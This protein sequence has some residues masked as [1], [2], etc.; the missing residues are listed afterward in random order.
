MIFKVVVSLL[1]VIFLSISITANAV[2]VTLNL[3]S[4]ALE[5]AFHEIR[6]QTGY[7]FGLL[8]LSIDAFTRRL[9][10]SKISESLFYEYESIINENKQLRE[11]KLPRSI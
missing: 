2:Q 9:N 3:K 7:G 11:S 8:M 6:K 10:M 4:V 1:L 5:T